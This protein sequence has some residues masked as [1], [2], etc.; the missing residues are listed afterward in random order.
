MLGSAL[1]FC[2]RFLAPLAGP[3]FFLRKK[4][5]GVKECDINKDGWWE[6]SLPALHSASVNQNQ[7]SKPSPSRPPS[8]S[9]CPP[10]PYLL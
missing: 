5:V 7:A 3:R 10:H 1:L 2:A 9:F 4:F 6:R 8:P